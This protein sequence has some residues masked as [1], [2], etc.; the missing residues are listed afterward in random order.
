MALRLFDTLRREEVVFE[1][2]EPGRVR[3]YTCG[4]TVH[5]FAHI[6]NLRTF[7]FEDLLRRV[8]EVRGYAVEQVMNLTDVDDKIIAK[9]KA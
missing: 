4:P 6:G 8:L 2:L 7:L 5:D 1:P 3:M 9:A